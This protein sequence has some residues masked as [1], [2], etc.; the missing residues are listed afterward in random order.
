MTAPIASTASVIELT[1]HLLRRD[2][3]TGTPGERVA[4]A[5]LAEL[6]GSLVGD[7]ADVRLDSDGGAL[8]VVP[9]RTAGPVLL[10][11]C[12]IDTVPVDDAEAWE[13]P[14]FGAVLRDGV[15]HGRGASDMKS[16]L[17]AAILAVRD[18]LRGGRDI[19]LAVTTGE[20]A[21]CLGAPALGALLGDEVLR[22][23]AAVIV[24]ESTDNAVALGHRG[25]F[26]VS[27]EMEGVAAHGSTPERGVNAVLRLAD[28]IGGLN[29]LPLREHAALGRESVNVGTFVGGIA[30]NIVPA[31]ALA[32]IDHRV[33]DADVSA[34]ADWWRARADDV[35]TELRLDPVWS[36][37]THDWIASLPAPPAPGPVSYFTDAS[38]LVG[39]LAPS[40]PIVV[41]GPGDPS[42]VHARNERVEAAAV[43]RAAELYR[44]VVDAWHPR[45][46]RPRG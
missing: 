20:E 18:G 13:H 27:V 38:V 33:V 8:A 4:L 45:G 37:A 42:T 2:A 39:L 43:E 46:G 35:R 44:V 19:A 32:R 12:H 41:W 36:D 9:D 26:W 5:E 15:L 23:V 30:P 11:S 6:V 24:P 22:R 28:A 34:I 14:P 29:T 21:G 3:T 16:G 17:A 31:A 7:L 10:F 1:R 40:T 25:A